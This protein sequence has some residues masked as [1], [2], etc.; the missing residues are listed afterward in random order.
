[1]VEIMQKSLKALKQ[2][3]II[4]SDEIQSLRHNLLMTHPK[5]TKAQ[6]IRIFTNYFHAKLDDTLAIFDRS[7]QN[8]IKRHILQRTHYD[9]PFIINAFD[10]VEIYSQIKPINPKSL[11]QLTSWVNQ[12]ETKPLSEEYLLWLTNIIKNGRSLGPFF[13]KDFRFKLELGVAV[14]TLCG[15]LLFSMHY[16]QK[17][18]S[19]SL[20]HLNH[21]EQKTQYSDKVDEPLPSVFMTK[22][23]SHYAS[24]PTSTTALETLKT[25]FLISESYATE[26]MPSSLTTIDLTERLELPH[27][28][29]HSQLQYKSINQSALKE[30]LVNRN[31][32][33]A[34]EPYFSTIINTAQTFNVNPLLLFAI[35]GQEQNFVPTSQESASKIANNPFNLYGSWK[36]YNTSI[37][38]SAR[39][40]ARTIVN[41]GEGCPTNEDQIKWIN[42]QYA[43]DPNWHIGVSYFLNELETITLT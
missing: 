25:S 21:I 29:L 20:M 3:S 15:S 2:Q 35:T 27:N 43:A 42:Q 40:A 10:I 12:Y 11:A 5:L 13:I 6:H 14:S 31:S 16:Q 38:D 18:Q 28:N 39:I 24:I 33:L 30:W 37:E 17:S 34:N 8:T 1:M 26:T 4:S 7:L 19:T 32:L 36:E 23:Y 41:L 22:T 9:K